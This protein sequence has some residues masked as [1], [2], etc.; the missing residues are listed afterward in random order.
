MALTQPHH[1]PSERWVSDPTPDLGDSV[2]LAVDV[3]AES[4][5]DHQHL[6]AGTFLRKRAPSTGLKAVG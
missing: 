5:F 3:P 2:E 6:G 4:G 1:D